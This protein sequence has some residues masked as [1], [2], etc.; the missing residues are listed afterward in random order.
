M[1]N[2]FKENDYTN[3]DILKTKVNYFK[4]DNDVETNLF[5]FNFPDIVEP[6]YL[7]EYVYENENKNNNICI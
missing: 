6:E 1:K 5:Y 3:K 2:F 7:V 4:I